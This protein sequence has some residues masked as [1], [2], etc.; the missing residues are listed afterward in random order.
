MIKSMMF[1]VAAFISHA[2][3]AMSLVCTNNQNDPAFTLQINQNPNAQPLGLLRVQAGP[4]ANITCGN[5]MDNIMR[6]Q[7]SVCA[8]VYAN[9]SAA[10]SQPPRQYFETPVSI[11][12]QPSAG[13][14]LAMFAL[15]V[16]FN[17]AEVSVYCQVYR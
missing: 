7:E 4:Y 1:I 6:N 15:P 2:A 8:G 13:A 10:D 9:D 3:L 12:I 17:S 16:Y 14:W 11:R 5:V